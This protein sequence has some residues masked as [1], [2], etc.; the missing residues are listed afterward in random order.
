MINK[1]YN[2]KTEEMKSKHQIN[3]TL[4]LSMATGIEYLYYMLLK[5]LFTEARQEPRS[6][7]ALVCTISLK[8]VPINK[9]VAMSMNTHEL[10][11]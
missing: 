8:H 5:N 9:A 1:S 6:P 10:K 4:L 11:V 7:I 2:I 3:I